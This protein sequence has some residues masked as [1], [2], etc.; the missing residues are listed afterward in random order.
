MIDIS[1]IKEKLLLADKIGA[2]TLVAFYP[3]D[4]YP[5]KHG[6]F[7]GMIANNRA[8]QIVNFYYENLGKLL[9]DKEIIEAWA[10]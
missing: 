6:N 5:A 8:Y 3:E 9:E 7:L 4:G 1:N 2:H 10:C